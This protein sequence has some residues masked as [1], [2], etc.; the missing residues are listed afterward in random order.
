MA[1]CMPDRDNMIRFAQWSVSQPFKSVKHLMDVP[2][3]R[4][5]S[6]SQSTFAQYTVSLCVSCGRMYV[7][8]V[9]VSGGCAYVVL[10]GIGMA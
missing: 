7:S 8:R 10:C 6:T 1:E 4:V 2:H 9:C 5:K 3:F